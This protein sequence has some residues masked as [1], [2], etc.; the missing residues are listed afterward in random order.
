MKLIRVTKGNFLFQFGKREKHLLTQVL[1]L[2]PRIP[3][4]TFRLSKSGKLPTAE[5]NHRLL[6]ES[7]A[8]LRPG[9]VEAQW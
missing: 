7:L 4:A 9:H 3:P 6:D 8:E 2:Y 1:R 5:A